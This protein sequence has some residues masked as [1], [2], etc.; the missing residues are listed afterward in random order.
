MIS[1]ENLQQPAYF[2]KFHP[3]NLEI[4]MVEVIWVTYFWVTFEIFLKLR[5]AHREVYPSENPSEKVRFDATVKQIELSQFKINQFQLNV[6]LVQVVS[7]V[8]WF[9]FFTGSKK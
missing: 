5:L 6:A 7:I 2:D 8:C 9:Y 1:V 4:M 3:R